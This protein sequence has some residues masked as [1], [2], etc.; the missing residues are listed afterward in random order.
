MHFIVGFFFLFVGGCSGKKKK[1]TN[2]KD[3][4]NFF[5]DTNTHAD[6]VLN[7]SSMQITLNMTI[8]CS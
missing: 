6:P 5:R 8:P 1:N 3:N 7:V 2:Y 4:G